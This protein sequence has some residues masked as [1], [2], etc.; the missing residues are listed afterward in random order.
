MGGALAA[1]VVALVLTSGPSTL[2]TV[3]AAETDVSAAAEGVF[4]SGSTFAGVSLQ[5]STFAIGVVISATGTAVGEFQTVL[6]GT[7][8][9]GGPRSIA[10]DGAVTSGGLNL[11]GSATFTGTGRLDLGDGSLPTNVPFT[12]TVT[13]GGLQLTVGATAL[14]TQTLGAGSIAIQ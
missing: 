9:L 12:A 10:L 5:G 7:S 1:V 13:T 2:R 11:D 8:L 14:P 3:A 4:P 6:L